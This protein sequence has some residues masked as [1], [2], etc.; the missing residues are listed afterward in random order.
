MYLVPPIKQLPKMSHLVRA[1]LSTGIGS[2]NQWRKILMEIRLNLTHLPQWKKR[3]MK[4][5]ILIKCSSTCKTLVKRLW[6]ITKINHRTNTELLMNS[7]TSSITCLPKMLKKVAT[8]WLPFCQ[9]WLWLDLSFLL[10]VG[11]DSTSIALKEQWATKLNW[12]IGSWALLPP[13]HQLKLP[14]LFQ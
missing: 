5:M 9:L 11:K 1:T 7:C 8:A 13:N 3:P 4:R 2:P 6:D 12:S 14:L 10:L